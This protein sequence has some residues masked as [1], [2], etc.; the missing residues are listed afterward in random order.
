MAISEMIP[1]VTVKSLTSKRSSFSA[2]TNP[3]VREGFALNICPS[4]FQRKGM[5]LNSDNINCGL[6]YFMDSRCFSN[7]PLK[8]LS[9]VSITFIRSPSSID[10]GTWYCSSLGANL[11]RFLVMVS[12]AASPHN[13]LNSVLTY[14][15]QKQINLELSRAQNP[16][17]IA[18]N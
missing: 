18:W 10:S 1:S 15:T 3:W 13:R 16:R 14:T 4:L 11:S 2:A 17:R 7:L 9:M 12:A 8:H 6:T 5:R